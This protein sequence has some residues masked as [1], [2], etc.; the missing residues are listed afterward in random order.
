MLVMHRNVY[1]RQMMAASA[2][3]ICAMVFALP[4]PALLASLRLLRQLP[5]CCERLWCCGHCGLGGKWYFCVFPCFRLCFT[6]KWS[7]LFL[8]CTVLRER[9]LAGRIV[10]CSSTCCW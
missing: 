4:S 10:V 5:Q 2:F 6:L 8:L 7:Y 9:G 3:Q 1:T